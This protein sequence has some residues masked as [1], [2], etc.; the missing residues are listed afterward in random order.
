MDVSSISSAAPQS[1]PLAEVKKAVPSENSEK[2]AATDTQLTQEVQMQATSE[3][4]KGKL[5][6]I[7][8]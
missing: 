1:A 7:M 8:A 6:D 3:S 2:L 4:G 5:L